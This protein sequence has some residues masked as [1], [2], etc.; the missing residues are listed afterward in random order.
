[1]KGSPL[2]YYSHQTDLPSLSD[3]VEESELKNPV[4][5]S[6]KGLWKQK[7]QGTDDKKG[8]ISVRTRR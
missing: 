4:T 3:G 7:V 6:T 1:V 5:H 2:P 8:R